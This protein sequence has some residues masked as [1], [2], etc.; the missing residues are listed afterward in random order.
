MVETALFLDLVT[1]NLI[2]W[3]SAIK[4]CD[5]LDGEQCRDVSEMMGI[6]DNLSKMAEPQGDFMGIV[7]VEC[8]FVC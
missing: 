8:D 6:D 7:G 5:F 1:K 2:S 4:S 3:V